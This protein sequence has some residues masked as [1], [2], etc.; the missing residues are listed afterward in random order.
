MM[1]EIVMINKREREKEKEKEKKRKKRKKDTKK[2]GNR[3][4]G[5]MSGPWYL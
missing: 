1:S 4:Q 3:V 5:V 2:S